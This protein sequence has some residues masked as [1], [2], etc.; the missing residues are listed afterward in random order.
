MIPDEVLATYRGD[1]Q[2]FHEA[3]KKLSR[4][5]MGIAEGTFGQHDTLSVLAASLLRPAGRKSSPYLPL[6]LER[7]PSLAENG[8]R[9]AM[10]AELGEKGDL[11]EDLRKALLDDGGFVVLAQADKLEETAC[12]ELYDAWSKDGPVGCRLVVILDPPIQEFHR[13][14]LQVIL[15]RAAK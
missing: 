2:A 14:I 13:R 10:S 11:R 4:K 6:V 5:P 3:L 12:K 1:L 15:E 8:L 9:K 7:L